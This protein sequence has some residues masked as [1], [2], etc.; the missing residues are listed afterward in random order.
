MNQIVQWYEQLA[1][2][3]KKIVQIASPVVVLL[4][5][6]FAIILPV[7]NLVSDLRDDVKDN[8]QAVVYL[9]QQAPQSS[10]SG[11]R[12]FSSL[13]SV[14]TSTTRQKQFQLARFEEKKN[15]EINVWFDE[16]SFDK[17]LEWLADLENDYGITTSYIN[18][19]QTQEIGIVRA[20]VRLVSS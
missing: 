16:I 8:K 7:N 19:S 9:H 12:S 20:N 17:M 5:I 15:G 18:I 3:D 11:K 14:V 1:E 2:R 4:L 6:I 10:G 13:T